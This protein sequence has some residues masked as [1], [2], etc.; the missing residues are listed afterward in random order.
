MFLL[1]AGPR[2]LPP[3]HFFQTGPAANPVFYSASLESFIP[4][5]GGV[6][7]LWREADHSPPVMRG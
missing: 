7:R 5:G 2:D 4:G 1:S 3:L 6:N